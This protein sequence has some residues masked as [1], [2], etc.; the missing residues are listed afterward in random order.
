MDAQPT[1]RTAADRL[2]QTLWYEAG[3]LLCITPLYVLA[4]GSNATES[5]GLL[6]LLAFAVGLW[7]AC[8]NAAFDWME[9]A[10]TG[11]TADLRPARW[12]LVHA[13]SLE[14][15]AIVVTTPLIAAWSGASWEIAFAQDV[16][17]TLAYSAYAFFFGLLYDRLFPLHAGHAMR[18]APAAS[19]VTAKR[20]GRKRSIVSM[21]VVVWRL[22]FTARNSPPAD[23]AIGSSNWSARCS[24][25]GASEA[26]Y[27]RM[28][29]TAVSPTASAETPS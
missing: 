28:A 16:G 8:F 27:S 22:A 19:R 4:T 7:T 2:R 3:G 10:S 18:T 5:A 12:R 20:P 14:G 21:F 11:R 29:S 24:P 26:R 15:G 1:M 25:T 23:S 17:L 9:G 13:L 6:T